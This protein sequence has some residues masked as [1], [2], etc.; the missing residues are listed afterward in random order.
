[1]KT[2]FLRMLLCSIS[3]F[4][5][6]STKTSAQYIVGGKEVDTSFNTSMNHIFGNLDKTKIPFGLLLDYAMEFT[7]LEN[8]NGLTLTDSNKIDNNILRQIYT[9]L[10][11]ARI[12]SVAYC[13]DIQGQNIIK[14]ITYEE[15]NILYLL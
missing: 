14:N 7:N 9:T 13:P 4:L 8:F 1:M 2:P 12:S 5:L 6:F 11:T 15:N 3:V 10:A